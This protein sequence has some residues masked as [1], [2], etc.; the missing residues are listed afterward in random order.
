MNGGNPEIAL[1]LFQHAQQL[2]PNDADL[3]HGLATALRLMGRDSES[4]MALIAALRV[5]PDHGPSLYDQ[6]RRQQQEGNHR[7][8][9]ETFFKLAKQGAATYDTFFGRG[10]SLYRSHNLIAAERW[11]HAA[12]LVDPDNH[13]P[14][15]IAM[16]YRVWGFNSQAVACLEHAVKLAPDSADA[17]W[18]LSQALLV[19]GELSVVSLSMSG[20]SKER[21][22]AN[23]LNRCQDGRV[24]RL[25]ARRSF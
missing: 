22:A 17:H 6:A 2:N 7:A 15:S 9:S 21:G 11:F 8:A 4:N 19:S 24:K 1:T 12:A 16:I 3:C 23:A 20:D 5:D 14:L 25:M 10:V 13:R 18:N